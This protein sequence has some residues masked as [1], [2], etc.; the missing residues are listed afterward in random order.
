MET[1]RCNIL[2]KISPLLKQGKGNQSNYLSWASPSWDRTFSCAFQV[3]P[4]LCHLYSSDSI[5][6]FSTFSRCTH[7]ASTLKW[8]ETWGG[9]GLNGL[10]SVQHQA[11]AKMVSW[12]GQMHS[13]RLTCSI[14][15]PCAPPHAA[16]QTALTLV[17]KWLSLTDLLYPEEKG[18]TH[19]YWC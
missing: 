19:L 17:W 12:V 8:A 7:S 4:N 1:R 5:Q 15:S 11:W 3:I 9:G 10:Q 2:P 6:I 13:F 14:N 16:E 18:Q